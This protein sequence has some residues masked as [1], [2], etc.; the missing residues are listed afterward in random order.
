MLNLLNI[1]TWT[2]WSWQRWDDFLDPGGRHGWCCNQRMP[3]WSISTQAKA[4]YANIIRPKIV[5][6]NFTTIAHQWATGTV[7]PMVVCTA[8]LAAK[9]IY[10]RNRHNIWLYL[11]IYLWKAICCIWSCLFSLPF[12]GGWSAYSPIFVEAHW[13]TAA[14]QCTM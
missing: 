1:W 10:L 13:R 3:L 2:Y 12:A 9:P 7:Q 14:V 4:I 11:A 6:I 5:P 8:Y